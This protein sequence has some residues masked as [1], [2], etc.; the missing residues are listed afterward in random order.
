MKELECTSSK[1]RK[2]HDMEDKEPASPSQG[3]PEVEKKECDCGHGKCKACNY[4]HNENCELHAIPVK[5]CW[6]TLKP[7]QCEHEWQ[8]NLQGT[9]FCKDCLALKDEQ[10]PTPELPLPE[11]PR[12]IEYIIPDGSTPAFFQ[13]IKLLMD[14]HNEVVRYLHALNKKS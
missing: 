3:G 5:M 12:E 7:R 8:K 4:C 13:D 9:Y 6:D 1:G 2:Y 14:A 10:K 11:L